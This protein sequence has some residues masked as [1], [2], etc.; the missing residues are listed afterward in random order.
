MSKWIE[1]ERRKKEYRE[2]QMRGEVSFDQTEYD[3]FIEKTAMELKLEEG[4]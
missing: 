3:K 1:Y 4:D 2:K